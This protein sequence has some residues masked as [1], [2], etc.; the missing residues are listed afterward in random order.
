[1]AGAAVLVAA[2]IAVVAVI[3][4]AQGADQRAQDA[5][6][7]AVGRGHCSSS[8]GGL[9]AAVGHSCGGPELSGAPPKPLVAG[10]EPLRAC[11]SLRSVTLPNTTIESAAADSGT[12]TTPAACR[13]TAVVTH[14]P[15]GDNVRVWIGLPLKNWNGRFQAIGGAGFAG[16]SANSLNQPLAAGYAAGAT[17]TGHQGGSGSFALDSNG[18]LNWQLVR[19]TAYLGIHE[20]TV[21]GKALTQAFYGTAPKRSYFN[22]CS[23]GGRQ[24]LMEAQRYP[25]DYDGIL[26][27]APAINWSK[28]LVA[29]LWPQLVMLDARNLVPRCKFNAANEAA[30]AACDG[31]DGVKDGIIGDPRR[32][33]YDPASL[34][35]ASI[36]DCETFTEA[37]ASVVRR[38]WEGPRRQ[39]GTRLWYG[40]ARGTPFDR[41]AAIEGIPPVGRPFRVALDWLRFFLAQDPNF[42]LSTLTPPQYE[43][44]FDQSVEQY[45]AVIATDNPDL[46]AF[47]SAGGKLLIWHGWADELIFAE[48]TI[49]YYERLIKQ[50]GGKDAA[51]RFAR[52]FM[53]PGVGHCAGGPGPLPTR[54]FDAL[55]KWVEDGKA[56]KTLD[57][58]R[59]DETGSVIRSRPLCPYPLVARYKGRGSTDDAS[60]F[61]CSAG[62]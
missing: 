26:A 17:D 14:P 20:M 53:A 13:V 40:M 9:L 52:L 23:T 45:S 21:T 24:G 6:L 42:D 25:A 18:R 44:F 57:A 8:R 27:V 4:E 19:D 54:A 46:S 49:D 2:V 47:R 29:E 22:G 5:A 15:A 12:G 28:F 51:A 36:G 41:L 35:G 43:Q 58:V 16:G 59:R 39:D 56:P 38:I 50:A 61:R 10:T 33:T 3:G 62:F 55:R 31:M 11:E 32:C 48:G 30:V 7:Q 37:D 60:N 1:M 34:V